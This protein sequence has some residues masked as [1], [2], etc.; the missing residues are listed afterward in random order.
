ML[1]MRNTM[2]E[3]MCGSGHAQTLQPKR[4]SA[5]IFPSCFRSHD[6]GCLF[7]GNPKGTT[8]ICRNI[9]HKSPLPHTLPTISRGHIF[10]IN[11]ALGRE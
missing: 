8:P 1:W 7:S 4:P 5:P 11:L 3:I 9:P 10:L 6:W 2:L